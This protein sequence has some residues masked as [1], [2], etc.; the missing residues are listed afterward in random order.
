MRI[1]PYEIWIILHIIWNPNPIILLFSIQYSSYLK[2]CLPRSM[3]SF[4]LQ[5]RPRA[6]QFFDSFSGDILYYWRHFT[7]Y[8]KRLPNLLSASWFQRNS[9]GIWVIL[10]LFC[11]N[12]RNLKWLVGFCLDQ[13]TISHRAFSLTWRAS[14]PI[15]W[16]K[17]KCLYKKR[18]QL[19]QDWF[20]TQT[21]PPFLCFGTLV[22]P[23]WRHVKTLY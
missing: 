22:W 9:R 10:I 2:T 5:L 17:I 7:G 6:S 1:T 3:L 11:W 14:T 8:R 12:H 16:N 19:P 18:V 21:W 20:G 4:C 13:C 23:T 15:C